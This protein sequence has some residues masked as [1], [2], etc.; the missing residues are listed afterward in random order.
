MAK[1]IIPYK[2]QMELDDDLP[3]WHELEQQHH[4]Q[5][6]KYHMTTP[7]DFIAYINEQQI[8]CIWITEDFFTYLGGPTPFWDHFPSS[9]RAIVVPWVGCDFIDG[10]RLREEKD[11]VLCNVGPNAASNVSDLCMHLVLSCFR[12]TSFMEHCF[13]FIDRGDVDACKDHIGSKKSD[14]VQ[15][16]LLDKDR[17]TSFSYTYPDK[18]QRNAAEPFNIVQNYNFGDKHIVSPTNKTALILGFGSI[19]QMIGKKLH[20]AFDMKVQYYKRSGPVSREILGYDA[21]YVG[22]LG[23]ASSWREADV[24]ILSLPSNPQS[25]NIINRN[26][27][28]MCKDGVRIVNVGRGSCVDEDALLEAL[29]S[30]KVNSCGLDVYKNE[31]TRINDALLSRWDVTAL[32]HLGSAVYDIVLLETQIT[33]ENIKDIFVDG[34]RGVY[35]VN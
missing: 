22:D 2:F 16:T 24:I 9:L 29:D 13:R 14:L 5:F 23:D 6:L 31:D 3:L 25:D 18:K 20:H 21:E 27:L 33:L 26:T 10:K 11:I 1:V 8:N 19:G 34:G 30:G 12:M 15:Q 17:N 28:A 32:P 7:E 35:T 4:V